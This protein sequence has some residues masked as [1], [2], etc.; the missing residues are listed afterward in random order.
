LTE[1]VAEFK[2]LDFFS[3]KAFVLARFVRTKKKNLLK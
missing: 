1:D 3:I 2:S